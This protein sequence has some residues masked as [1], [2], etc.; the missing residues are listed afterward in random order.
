MD[1]RTICVTLISVLLFQPV[2]VNAQSLS[3]SSGSPTSQPGIGAAPNGVPL[4]DIVTPNSRGLSHNKYDQFNIGT[5]GLILNNFSGEVGTSM[6]GGI[7][8]G[9]RNLR[10]TGSATVILNEVTSGHRSQL[11]G[12]TEVF[13]GRAD[14]IIANPNGITCDGC[15]F[16]NTPR[17]TLTTGNPDVG[18]DGQLQGFSVRG[19]D[20]TFGKNGGNF[21][22][23]QGVVDIFDVV[24]RS[25]K[26]DG[27]LFAKDLRV[28][29]G[30]NKSSYATGELTPLEELSGTPEF[31]LDGSALGA[32]QADRIKIVVTDKGAGVRVK[33][34]MAANVGELSLSAD[35]KISIGN[36]SGAGGVNIRSKASVQAGQITSKKRLAVKADTGI[37]ITS[38]AAED[39]V[40]MNAGSGLL[41]VAGDIAGSKAVFL[42]AKNDISTGG[43]SAQGSLIIHS[44]DGN[45][46]IDQDGRAGDDVSVRAISGSVSAGSLVSF[47]NLT[48]EA[49]LDVGIVKDLLA[50]GNIGATGRSIQVGSAVSGLDVAATSVNSEATPVV[51]QDGD[52]TLRATADVKAQSL[53][54]AGALD[55]SA[56][57]TQIKNAN[58]YGSIHIEG[59]VEAAEDIIAQKSIKITANSVVADSITSGFIFSSDQNAR[60]VAVSVPATDITIDSAGGKIDVRSI[61]S[62]GDLD[63][64]SG[65]LESDS[66]VARGLIAIQGNASVAEQMLAGGD[67]FLSGKR[68]SIGSLASGVNFT[69][70][71]SQSIVVGASGDVHIQ[72]AS[73]NFNARAVLTGGSFTAEAQNINIGNITSNKN[74]DLNGSV[75]TQG[76]IIAGGNVDFTGISIA[77]NSIFAGNP[78]SDN[79]TACN[80]SRGNI[81]IN[82]HSFVEVG[83]LEGRGDIALKSAHIKADAVTGRANIS[84]NTDVADVGQLLSG[85]GIDIA[86]RSLSIE[87][88][89]AGMNF[90]E[91]ALAGHLVLENSGHLTINA[92]SG[93]LDTEALMSASDM[94][95]NVNRLSASDITAH[96]NAEVVGDLNVTGKIL[97][98]RDLSISG[99]SITAELAASGVDFDRT[100]AS[101]GSLVLGNTGDLKLDVG[102]R[103]DE[104]KID[105]LQSA[106]RLDVQTG[107][108]SAKSILS[109]GDVSVLGNTYISDRLLSGGNVE[110][111]G[112]KH[113]IQTLVS[114]VD[115]DATRQS[116]TGNILLGNSGDATITAIY[117]DIKFDT[118]MSA[119]SSV[120]KAD[121]VTASN[122]SSHGEARVSGNLTADR[123][124]S[125]SNTYISGNN[126]DVGSLASGVDFAPAQSPTQG[127]LLPGA[128]GN[129]IIDAINGHVS[130]GSILSAN[131][132]ESRSAT[133]SGK[134][135]NSGG[136]VSIKGTTFIEGTVLAGNDLDIN[137]AAI[138]A[139]TLVSGVDFSA[140]EAISSGKVI[141]K[142]GGNIHLTASS[143]DV[144]AA[145]LLSAEN[146]VLASTGDVSAQITG[147]GNVSINAGNTIKLSSQTL[148]GGHLSL[149]ARNVDVDTAI[150]GVDFKKTESSL[151]GAIALKSQGQ[152]NITASAGS[153]AA[154]NLLS[155]GGLIASANQNISYESLQSFDYA[156]L[157]SAAGTISIN[158]T[159][160]AAGDISLSARSLDFRESRGRVATNGTLSISADT[161]DFSNSTYSFGNFDLKISGE[162]TLFGSTIRAL[163]RSGSGGNVT[164][165]AKSI[166]TNAQTSL[167]AERDINLYTV[168]FENYGQV[169]AGSNL[170]I[171][172][173]NLG[174]FSTGLLYSGRDTSLLVSDEILND[175]GAI[176]SGSDLTIAGESAG[177]DST[178]LTNIS[179]LIQADGDLSIKTKMLTNKRSS[180]PVIN[181]DV[182]VATNVETGFKLNSQVAGMPFAH[183]FYGSNGDGRW[184]YQDLPKQYW[185]DYSD[186]LWSE[187]K[188]ADGTS[189]RAW[190]WHSGNGPR[191]SDNIYNWIAS[192]APRDSTGNLTLDPSNPSKYFVVQYEGSKT[193]TSTAYYWDANSKVTQTIRED[194]IATSG[195][196]EAVIRAAR[197]LSI[198]ADNLTNSYSTIEAG[199][200]AQL[201]GGTLNNEGLVLRRTTSTTCNALGA[202]EGYDAEGNRDPSRDIAVGTS[203]LSQA[204]VTGVEAGLI[205]A[206]GNLDIGGFTTVS[207]TSASNSIA[208][209]SKIANGSSVGNP[210]LALSGLTAGEAL[211]TPN[212]A[213]LGLNAEVQA[214]IG[215]PNNVSSVITSSSIG[216]TANVSV[217]P[218]SPQTPELMLQ[219]QTIG[220]NQ[221]LALSQSTLSAITK[222]NSGG[223]GG[224]L[225]GQ[226]FLFETR[227]E[228]LDVSKFYGSGYYASRIGYQPDTQ[229]P[230][231]GDAYFENQLINKQIQQATGLRLGS[232]IFSQGKDAIEE[233]KLLLDNGI[234]YA[235]ANNLSIGEKLSPEQLIKL[236]TSI[237]VYEKHTVKGVE[238][239]APVVYLASVDKERLSAGGAIIAGGYLNMDVGE[240]D[241]SG[242]IAADTDIAVKAHDIRLNGGS[243]IAGGNVHLA[244]AANITLTAQSIDMRGMNMI[245]P[246]PAISAGG[247]VFLSANDNL[248]LQGTTLAAGGVLTLAANS[249]T[250]DSLKANN[251]GSQNSTGSALRAGTD[252]AIVSK[253]DVS[254]IG[255]SAKAG[256]DLLI[257]AEQG[258]VN[259]VTAGVSRKTSDGYTSMNEISQQDSVLRAG[260]STNI[261]AGDDILLS[262]SSIRSGSDVALRAKDDINITTAQEA[263]SR[264]FGSSAVVS[265]TNNAS[266]IT[267]GGSI[268]AVAGTERGDH[269]INIVGSKLQA[270]NRV[271]LEAAGDLTI[272]EAHDTSSAKLAFKSGR[273]KSKSQIGIE[274][275]VGSSISG[276]SGIGLRSGEDTII[277]ASHLDTGD[278][279]R[280]A[281]LNISAGKDIVISSG[282]NVVEL[283]EQ[284]TSKGFLRK[285]S[286]SL[287][288]FDEQTV[289][290]Q[291]SASGNVNL[292]AQDNIAVSG[293]SLNAEKS[294][295]VEGNSVV[296]M[297]AEEQH[298][299]AEKRKKSGL[300]A[301]SGSG[302]FSL[303]GKEQKER[304]GSSTQNVASLLSA[305]EDI[306][307]NA[308]KGDIAVIGSMLE[309]DRDIRLSAARDVSVTPGAE[310]YASQEKEK[311]SGFGISFGS[312]NGGFSIGLGVAKSRDEVLQSG[313]INS[314][315]KISAGRDFSI[316]PGQDANLQAA[317]AFAARDLT[318]NAVR[319]VNLLSAM[320]ETN[321]ARIHEQMFAGVTLSV[322][323]K[324]VAAAE[325]VASAANGLGG[326]NA[327]YSVAPTALS[328]YKAYKELQAVNNGASPI[329]SIGLNVGFNSQKSSQA[330]SA[331]APVVT[332]LTSGG[333]TAVVAE[334]GNITGNGAQIAAGFDKAG[335]PV[336]SNDPSAGNVLLSAGKDISLSSAQASNSVTSSSSSTGASIGL[337]VD[338]GMGGPS[339]GMKA[340][341]SHGSA[342]S[343]SA[344]TNEINSRVTGTGT[345]ALNSG[346]DTNLKGAVVSGN[347]IIANVGGDL[348]I[349]SRQNTATYDEKSKNASI[350]L[351]ISG[352]GVKVS[353][354][355]G[356]AKI[357]GDYANVAEQSGIVAG[358]GGYHVAAEGGVD[359]KAGVIASSAAK[360]N[361]SLIADHLTY[362]DI[363]NR[364]EASTSAS[365][366]TLSPSGI[367][368]PSV[369]QPAKEEET[370]GARA[371]LTPG[372]LTLTNQTQDLA[373]LNTDLSKANTQVD[374]FDIDRLK[375]RQQSA[376]A[377]SELL[378]IGVGDLSEQ[379]GFAEGSPVKVA[380]HAAVGAAVAAMAGTDV[381]AGALAGALSEIAN[382]A[383]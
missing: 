359:L 40:E 190:T 351:S 289:A 197:N 56:A 300:F 134:I 239:L 103:S 118:L 177:I 327:K 97:A 326:E 139:G 283:Q 370:G 169:A 28:S 227:A 221:G 1:E 348:S 122:S 123:I 39:D 133:F 279:D 281:D 231:L 275:A 365:G 29:L 329:A 49:G 73:G 81:S 3:A 135:I 87:T 183:L 19:G 180:N 99:S 46:N 290:S 65:A 355:A 261:R 44:S 201:R 278:K 353:G 15:G 245:V 154:K 247:N 256:N 259:V 314:V 298:A 62:A 160:R 274:T 171:S 94:F 105:T 51:S 17:A 319:D 72:T 34:G 78:N 164:I 316:D 32:M 360:N 8:P 57:K 115:F 366:I 27:P 214:P 79:Q 43:V 64:K 309:A 50:G 110:I 63:I 213:L 156:D 136:N 193:D 202:C 241:N 61:D 55:I 31:A 288:R 184:L 26:I 30:A 373:S 114:G 13:G 318:V 235:K 71:Y 158:H 92:A 307:V 196:E 5:P 295:S 121:T 41:T 45:I 313:N 9:N 147:R 82:A 305:G 194:Q 358:S 310:A 315:A 151:S 249:I 363:E 337:S 198:T 343:N 367:P 195:G 36:T 238:V 294:V 58:S 242:V 380:L 302:F 344:I 200:N 170:N 112:E 292:N 206:G 161:A 187:V 48:I 272:A 324:L 248:K 182:L 253:N 250:L 217:V 285:S 181:R 266:S 240:I 167:L 276:G 165:D 252:I 4:I 176:L 142:D 18:A 346:E 267:S 371:T 47:R 273:T 323:S 297:G 317:K 215:G 16:I 368:L 218:A 325:N 226:V 138:N 163:N 188:L 126:I 42:G 186:K 189:W 10:Q 352:G 52:L 117:G 23:G 383:L 361:N 199:D 11:L 127:S 25:L 369:S 137:G 76:N 330:A 85:N 220:A 342:K 306:N 349:E 230:F 20:V 144:V 224:T 333:S 347:T 223:F 339:V 338:I 375:A 131:D 2:L 75:E 69:N 225:P 90:K 107:N 216:D 125:G 168:D 340:E 291:L 234:E 321:Y 174:N 296:I 185:Q 93:I 209:G 204:A 372:N 149:I 95:L 74:I 236:T 328:A 345:V 98:A 244:S 116:A 162:A 379:L 311:K 14:V 104:I 101:D 265:Q 84:L 254:I 77:A 271:D 341:A 67:I 357:E 257:E 211:F 377:L 159:T 243:F 140:M 219:P 336:A 251:Q 119:G 301:G 282:K 260:G 130:V 175:R 96:G 255:S 228:F 113:S 59:N 262:G 109:Q 263:N 335:K 191:W 179:G 207:N 308:R 268:S 100:R 378:N 128:N 35:G 280:L 322:T 205:K 362:S 91:T 277:S 108:L 146:T 150:A 258:S 6:L 33:S 21:A 24:S 320:D 22:S 132:V 88:V 141:L 210:L 148:A 178:T 80:M 145:S 354:G 303:W 374:P 129:V 237:V 208:G 270:V 70:A 222:P 246:G 286:S 120:L 53:L 299:Y 293:S 229:I 331:F 376:A 382:A 7:T 111:L 89:I 356:T 37:V 269:D 287:N 12:P 54:S 60:N 152:L 83:T 38:L 312:G 232:G 143:G 155:A 173:R 233:M 106:G 172:A 334:Q 350:G 102:V 304:I 381:G 264:S 364:S 203:V 86:G 153:I 332:E 212:A 124:S 157:A 192:V 66:I 68:I 284:T 166:K